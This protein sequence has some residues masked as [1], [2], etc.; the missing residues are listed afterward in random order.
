M[1]HSLMHEILH[2]KTWIP[3]AEGSTAT[4]DTMYWL[5]VDANFIVLFSH[6]HGACDLQADWLT[7]WQTG[8]KCHK[9]TRRA[10]STRKLGN[11]LLN[12]SISDL[13]QTV[14][15]WAKL[16]ATVSFLLWAPTLMTCGTD[17]SSAD[18]AENNSNNNDSLR[19]QV[20][21]LTA[22]F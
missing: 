7:A 9:V 1:N 12:V 22:S 8:I 10:E 11:I 3:L 19:W 18:G 16:A 15:I 13:A 20:A 2:D 5:V 6:S 4:Y 21:A 14:A 17:N